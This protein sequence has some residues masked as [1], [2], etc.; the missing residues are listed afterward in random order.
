MVSW[1]ELD[2][3]VWEEIEPLI[4][5]RPP[6]AVSRMQG[7]P[8]RAVRNGILHVLQTAHRSRPRGSAAATAAAKREHVQQAKNRFK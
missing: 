7:D 8:D 6:E 3:D 2:E 4:P 1:F 5:V